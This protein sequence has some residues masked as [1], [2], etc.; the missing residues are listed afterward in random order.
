MKKIAAEYDCLWAGGLSATNIYVQGGGKEKAQ[1]YFKEQAEIFVRHGAD[2]LIAEVSKQ[3]SIP[4]TIPPCISFPLC[5]LGSPYGYW[6]FYGYGISLWLWSTPWE[7]VVPP[8]RCPYGHVAAS[9][10]RVDPMGVGSL[11]W[12]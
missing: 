2:F 1:E 7:Y 4:T 5:L 8:K 12:I 9:M 10:T 6:F 11:V 3:V